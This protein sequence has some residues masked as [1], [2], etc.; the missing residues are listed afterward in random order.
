MQDGRASFWLLCYLVTQKWLFCECRKCSLRKDMLGYDR[1]WN[2]YWMLEGSCSEAVAHD[3]SPASCWVYV[4]RCH[5]PSGGNHINRESPDDEEEELPLG[6][7]AQQAQHEDEGIQHAKR[8]KVQI[9]DDQAEAV[10][11]GC[12]RSIE[13]VSKLIDY[14]NSRGTFFSTLADKHEWLVLLCCLCQCALSSQ[15]HLLC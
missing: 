3:D 1:H 6:R 8:Q 13:H 5:P 2:R 4:E 15:C 10:S 7:L 14:L 9:P 11:W 12:Y